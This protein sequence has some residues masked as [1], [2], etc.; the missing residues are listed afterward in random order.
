MI[1][2]NALLVTFLITIITARA[3]SESDTIIIKSDI[4]AEKIS[5]IAW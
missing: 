3:A 5:R 4:Y 2:L 1:R